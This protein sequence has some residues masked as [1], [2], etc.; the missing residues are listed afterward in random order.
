LATLTGL[1]TP[2]VVLRLT[3][4]AWLHAGSGVTGA[5]AVGVVVARGRGSAGGW[6]PLLACVRRGRRWWW[7]PECR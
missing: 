1:N 5:H 2:L 3:Q 4:L 6:L 7:L